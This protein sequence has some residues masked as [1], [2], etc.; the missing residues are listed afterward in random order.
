MDKEEK[1]DMLTEV[2]AEKAETHDGPCSVV[3][4][5]ADEVQMLETWNGSIPMNKVYSGR[6]LKTALHKVVKCYYTEEEKHWLESVATECQE[7]SDDVERHHDRHFIP[8]T[9]IIRSVS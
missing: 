7:L 3:F 8:T 5:F 9:C 6:P 1:V 4:L 2:V